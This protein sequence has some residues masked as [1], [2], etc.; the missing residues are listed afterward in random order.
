[1]KGASR[2]VVTD[3]PDADLVDNLH[4]NIQ[5]CGALP[6]RSIVTSEVRL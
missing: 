5:H 3:Y 2:V 1:M 6:D 4:Y